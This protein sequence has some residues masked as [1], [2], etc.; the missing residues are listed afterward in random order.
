VSE[1]Q[2]I[3]EKNRKEFEI[4]QVVSHEETIEKIQQMI[5][6]S[7]SVIFM[8]IDGK[9]RS[10]L[11]EYCFLHNK[12]SYIM[13][14]FSDIMINT[15][16]ITWISDTPVYM[17]KSPEPDM[18]TK[19]IKRCMDI[20]ISLIAIVLLS[21]LMLITWIAIILYDRQKAI[22]KQ[23][24]VT[25][26]GKLFTLYKFRSMRMDAEDDGIPRLTTHDDD[27]ITPIGRI[28]RRTRIDE[29]P[30]LFNVLSGSMSL[31]GPRPER[32]E[33][34]EQYE[35]IYPNFS[36]RTKV[37]AGI[38]GFA[39]IHGRY[40]TAPDEKL[41]MDIMYIETFSIWQDIRLILQTLK[42]LF[43]SSSSEGIPKDKETA[44]KSNEE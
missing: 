37:K 22:Y 11:L 27:R 38:T 41:L 10:A 44:L 9:H 34:A 17:P 35:K 15:A 18:G 2:K 31:V 4:V 21:W 42:V 30:Q 14:S 23:V 19:F 28:I 39:Q 29:L 26:G 6:A 12:R 7:D 1:L 33:I 3:I 36:L 24:R 43:K 25:K 13:P 5:D 32:P 16:E 20:F 8:E 40:S